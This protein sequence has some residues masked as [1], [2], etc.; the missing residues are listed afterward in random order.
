MVLIGVELALVRYVGPLVL[1]DSVLT[2]LVLLT[3][4]AGL[5]LAA[6]T[7]Q[8]DTVPAWARIRL[9]L[10][11]VLLSMG[12]APTYAVEPGPV[13][14]SAALIAELA[15]AVLLMSTVLALLRSSIRQHHQALG[16]LGD[17][18]MLAESEVRDDRERLH[19][20][21]SMVAGIVS[22]SR[23]VREVE[24]LPP[25]RRDSLEDMLESE[26]GRLERLMSPD[27]PSSAVE[28][29]DLDDVVAPLVV[30]HQARGRVVHWAPTGHVVPARAD[31][32][33]EV[34]NVLLENAARHAPGHP[35]E[36]SVQETV[37]RL[38][39]VVS[40]TGPGIAPAVREVLYEWGSRAA[41]SSGQGIG[42]HVARRMME[43]Q[44]GDL[45]LVDTPGPG[46]T[47]VVG[48]VQPAESQ[49]SCDS[50][51]TSRGPQP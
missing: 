22:A 48:L 6:A 32:L 7:L 37:G 13:A 20:I 51:P 10:V 44:G 23:L 38:H 3:L 28:P 26:M 24:S 33:T 14:S 17:R 19:E 9:A 46:A 8:V 15:G 35:V 21:G 30:A 12:T 39:I 31:D 16:E 45:T 4:L 27:S 50:P 47:F 25:D 29:V 41:T 5:A 11:V 42:L 43:A 34:L 18:L 36:I 40:D 2:T 1:A 49:A